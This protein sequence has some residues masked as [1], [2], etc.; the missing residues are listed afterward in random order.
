MPALD[1]G[2]ERHARLPIQLCLRAR[3]GVL[4]LGTSDIDSEIT[5]G[6]GGADCAL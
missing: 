5:G 2:E 4:S 6:R 1:E 3:P